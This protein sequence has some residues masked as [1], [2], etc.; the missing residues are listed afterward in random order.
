MNIRWNTFCWSLEVPRDLDSSFTLTNILGVGEK[1]GSSCPPGQPSPS[2]QRLWT[3]R[4]S[5]TCGQYDFP[6]PFVIEILSCLCIPPP[7]DSQKHQQTVLWTAKPLNSYFVA[8]PHMNM[9]KLNL[10]RFQETSSGSPSKW[11]VEPEQ[12]S[13]SGDSK[14][15][16]SCIPSLHLCLALVLVSANLGGAVVN[17]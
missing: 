13:E 6:I 2:S 14:Q 15:F 5:L 11:V 9:K 16:L 12:S 10:K 1:I 7:S 3:L 4:H 17:T 8:S